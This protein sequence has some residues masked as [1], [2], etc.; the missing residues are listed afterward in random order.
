MR[1]SDLSS[2]QSSRLDHERITNQV[3]CAV[4][5]QTEIASSQRATMEGLARQHSQ[6]R[7]E[8][9]QRDEA[10]VLCISEPVVLNQPVLCR[11]AEEVRHRMYQM[12][13]PPPRAALDPT[14]DLPFLLEDALGV[15]L[16]VHIN[17]IKDGWVVSTYLCLHLC[18]EQPFHQRRVY[19]THF[20]LELLRTASIEV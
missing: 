9:D 17:C 1:K 4:E 13:N 20:W 14:M 8:V 12:S 16:T 19:L 11:L 5:Q 3:T 10:L 2:R 7:L 18:K 15:L 6:L